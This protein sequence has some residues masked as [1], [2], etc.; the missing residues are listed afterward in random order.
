MSAAS[1]PIE[2]RS[3]DDWRQV[4]LDAVARGADA[5]AAAGGDGTQALVAT[6]AM[7]LLLWATTR[8]SNWLDAWA[9][10]HVQRN[11]EH[12]AHVAAPWP[13]I[14]VLCYLH[15]YRARTP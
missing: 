3:G 15:R 11:L 5:L 1:E 10:R 7:V 9:V 14:K 12:L 4:V 2:L 6:I 8:L 13:E